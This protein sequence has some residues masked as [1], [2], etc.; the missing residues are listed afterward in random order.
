[1]KGHKSWRLRYKFAGKEKRLLL[2][3]YPEVSLARARELREDAKRLL[4]DHRDPAVEEHKRKIAA[5]A[6]AGA[7][8]EKYALLWHEVQKG[9]WSPVQIKKVEQALRRDVFPDLGRLPL[10]EIDGPMILK[11]LRKVEKRGAID[12]AKR[13][14]QYVSAVFQFAMTEGVVGTDPASGIKKGLL[15]TPPGGRQPAVRQPAVRTLAEARKLLAD[16][17][18]STSSPPTK[19]ASRLLALTATRPGIV[20]AA[21][22]TEFE[23][24]DWDDPDLS[25]PKA[26]WRV[27]AGRMK[28]EQADKS[29]ELFEHVMPLPSEAV[30]VLRAMH[31]LTGRVVYVFHAARS[32]RTPMSE[33][34]IGYMYAR[35]LLRPARAARLAVDVLDDYERARG[36]GAA[37]GGSRNYR[38]HA[39]A[40]TQWGVGGGDGVRSRPPLG[41]PA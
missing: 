32:V 18:A 35:R 14:R 9:R 41:P 20:R 38:R 12:T 26:L 37:S 29:D 40:E 17:D 28:L 39:R 1:M 7:T 34:T 22:W 6:A 19:L 5:H 3:E 8:F 2:G 11:V 21:R 16:M 24:I 10:A 15:P 33:N 13:I 23:G 25:A 27:P 31:R 4:R 36:R 30:G